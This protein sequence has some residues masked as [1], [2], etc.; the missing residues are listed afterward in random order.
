MKVTTELI[1]KTGVKLRKAGKSLP[2][3]EIKPKA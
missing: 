2:K 1:K 3:F